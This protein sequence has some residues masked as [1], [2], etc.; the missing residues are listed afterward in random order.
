MTFE[1]IIL[2]YDY[3]DLEPYIDAETIET[4][5]TKHHQTYTDKFNWAISWT[6]FDNWSVEDILINEQKLPE[7]IRTIVHNN[8]WWYYNHN[9][10]FECLIPWWKLPSES[11]RNILTKYFWWYEKF[12]ELFSN[13]AISQ[14]GSWRA[15]LAKRW[16]NL[17]AYWLQNQ[18]TALIHWDKPI[19][20][21][22][23][24]EHAYYLKYKNLRPD[25]VSSFWNIVNWDKI[26]SNYNLH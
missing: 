4:H 23:V 24:W 9:I 21:L 8:W 1:K 25:Y 10:Y 20:M 16:D 3:H 13:I 5:Y 11:M 19:F 6:E 17:V 18:D 12:K 15:C 26:E 22:D 14:F 7:N 2:P